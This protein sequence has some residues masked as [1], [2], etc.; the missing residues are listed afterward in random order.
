MA[1]QKVLAEHQ[2]LS[3]VL[4]ADMQNWR[5]YLLK[6]DFGRFVSGLWVF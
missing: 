1:P 5:W 2:I 3:L 4:S 6:F